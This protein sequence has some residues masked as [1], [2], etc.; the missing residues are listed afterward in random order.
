MICPNQKRRR[1]RPILAAF[2][3][4]VKRGGGGGS[5]RDG[6]LTEQVTVVSKRKVRIWF[7]SCVVF[8]LSPKSLLFTKPNYKNR[9]CFGFRLQRFRLRLSLTRSLIRRSA[10]RSA[11]LWCSVWCLFSRLGYTSV[12]RVLLLS[13]ASHHDVQVNDEDCST[14]FHNNG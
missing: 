14:C 1:S 13:V 12:L 7:L 3:Q 6:E 11:A 9:P 4:E 8:V 10:D 5:T 2:N